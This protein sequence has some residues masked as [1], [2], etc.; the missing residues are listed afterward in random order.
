[1]IFAVVGRCE[2]RYVHTPTFVVLVD[3]LGEKIPGPVDLEGMVSSLVLGLLF[4]PQL[5][6]EEQVSTP[7]NCR[8]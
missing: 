6:P 2:A 3:A 1:M 5:A 7:I 8:T 4:V